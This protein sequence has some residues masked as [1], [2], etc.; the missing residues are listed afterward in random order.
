MQ[1]TAAML[2]VGSRRPSATWEPVLLPGQEPRLLGDGQYYGCFGVDSG[3]GAFLDIAARDA[4]I[5]D[6]DSGADLQPPSVAR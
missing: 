1:T 4:L 6:R 3:T 5:S 2:A